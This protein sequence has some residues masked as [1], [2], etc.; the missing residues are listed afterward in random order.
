[1]AATALKTIHGPI[2]LCAHRRDDP[3]MHSNERPANGR[4]S[5]AL[6]LRLAVVVAA[7]ASITTLIPA[8]LAEAGGRRIEHVAVRVVDESGGGL[9]GASVMACP[10][11]NGGADCA[12]S[13]VATTNRLGLAGLNLRSQ[14][15]YEIKAFVQD[16]SPPW[17]CPG[18]Q[19]DGHQ[20]YY[21]SETL[22]STP[23][24]LPR[25]SLL[26][27]VPPDPFSCVT[28]SIT[29]Q[30]GAPLPEALLML[31]PTTVDGSPCPSL[32]F[33][34]PDPDGVIRLD[35]DPTLTYDIT[36][37]IV[38][39]GWPCPHYRD[40]GGEVFHFSEGY[41]IVGAELPGTEFVITHPDPADCTEVR[42]VD[43]FG[44]PRASAGVMACPVVAGAPDCEQRHGQM[45]DQFG[46]ATLDLDPNVVYSVNAFVVDP[47]PAWACPGFEIDGS[48]F[49]FSQGF[50]VGTPAEIALGAPLV[51]R[52]PRA[53]DCPTVLTASVRVTDVDGV[54]LPSGFVGVCA[55]A[56]DGTPCTS[57]VYEGPDPDGVI[58]FQ[59][60][61]GVMYHVGALG[62]NLDWPCPWVS[63][64][65]T[66]FHFSEG[67]DVSGSELELG[68]TLVIHRPDEESCPA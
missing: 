51:I 1:M 57:T 52:E 9:A 47:V 32:T 36:A 37:L 24:D 29:D 3:A 18:T 30:T 58:R 10:V 23:N 25:L 44:A 38:D 61:P 35:V 56:P 20:R 11:T 17:A 45:T 12:G 64:D 60:E 28:V 5:L 63:D 62:E 14:R 42:V 66:E 50:L 39:S 21:S 55:Y 48:Q 15:L 54:V 6:R 43:E 33:D 4:R 8:S 16:P 53:E 22:T 2:S 68:I 46:V 26:T 49:Y 59:V 31:C 19:V 7:M 27:I 65:G 13:V 40:E 67:R 41:R 34:G